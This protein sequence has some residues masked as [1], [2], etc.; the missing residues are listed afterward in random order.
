VAFDDLFPRR[1]FFGQSAR[2][3][4]WSGD[5][6]YVGYLW[7]PYGARGS[8]LWVY[9]TK[10]GKASP[11]T[12]IEAMAEFD[13]EARRAKARYA[14]EDAELDERDKLSEKEYREDQIKRRQQDEERRQPQPSYP[15][16]SDFAWSNKGHRVLLVYRGDLFLWEVGGRIRRLT[17]TRGAE[18]DPRWLPGDGAL[19][20]R[21]DN[22]IFRIRLDS[23]EIEQLDP[24]LPNNMPVWGY[25][26]S[27][28]GKWMMILSG[29]TTGQ[30]KQIEWIS[31]RGR[32][33]Q[34]QRSNQ[35]WGTPD[36]KIQEE[37]FLYLY[38]MSEPDPEANK[39]WEVWAWKSSGDEILGV[40]TSEHPWSPDGKRFAF[41]AYSAQTRE[42]EVKIAK[43]DQRKVDTVY[44]AKFLGED[45]GAAQ[46]E[47]FWTK[48][49]AG[50]VCL[51]ESTGYRLP[52]LVD[53]VTGSGRAL[54][55][56]E[57]QAQP[58][59][60]SED[61]KWLLVRSTALHPA[62]EQVYR[63]ALSDGRM[64]R[65][66]RREGAYSP[67]AAS[68]SGRA[69][70]A[71]FASWASP[72]EACIVDG[73]AEPALT[74]SHRPGAFQK[75]NVAQPKLFS[76]INRHGQRIHGFLFLPPGFDKSQRR[77]CMVYVYGGPLGEGNSVRDGTFNSTGYLFNLFLAQAYG[78]VTATVD[79]RG[80]SGYGASFVRASFGNVGTPQTEDLVDLA[81][82]LQT[83]YNV[84][85]SK[86]ALN[87][88][89]FGGWQTQ[90]VMYTQPGVYTLGIAGAG[91]TEWQNYNQGYTQETIGIAKEGS[92]EELDKFSLTKVAM[93]LRDPL[94]L[95]H[96]MEDSNVLFQH[97]IA[98]YRV[99]CQ[100]GK[101]PLVEFVPDPTGG[102]GLGGDL[103]RRDTLALYLR[104]I[105]KH[106]GEKPYQAAQ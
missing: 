77:P 88:W 93:N 96:G 13:P 16:V 45:D 32:F 72:S 21:R 51:M 8:D 106:W 67:Q 1:P 61:G 65:L 31:Y 38:D 70:F 84:D 11:V 74:D 28:D 95:L 53:P 79:P 98:V 102:H 46:C 12:S 99:L 68:H 24:E 56:G 64:E 85:P 35:F 50:L 47:P 40:S 5:D 83:E 54:V 78:F 2:A 14:K 48:D 18:T 97:T 90:H 103:N 19:T 36:E 86:M 91:P 17:R 82:H 55:Q 62:Q 60:L 66:S 15:G 9:D 39:P 71:Q 75:V 6:R 29:R 7:N 37:R 44:K 101:A 73:G 59:G 23:A 30:Y 42:V 33:A 52:W 92:V 58:L 94:M 80:S 41:A 10:T 34:V 69:V 4:A 43:L 49:G 22:G 76:F 87:G 20:F 105:L 57:F 100:H 26:L 104:F 63:I 3:A 25:S 27:P 89:S 81:K